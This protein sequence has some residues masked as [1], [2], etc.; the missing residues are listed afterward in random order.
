[1]ADSHV[2]FRKNSNAP[3]C[4]PQLQTPL[5]PIAKNG[6][7]RAFGFRGRLSYLALAP[8]HCIEAPMPAVAPPE[9]MPTPAFSLMRSFTRADAPSATA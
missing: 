7:A 3:F 6:T 2:D 8:Y 5:P 1:M 9:A 4:L